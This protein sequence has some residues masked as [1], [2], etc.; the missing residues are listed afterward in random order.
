[1]SCD[2]TCCSCQCS[3]GTVRLRGTRAVYY[4]MRLKQEVGLVKFSNT[5]SLHI[6]YTDY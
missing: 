3:L 4:R 5:Q 1:M 6:E 2:Q